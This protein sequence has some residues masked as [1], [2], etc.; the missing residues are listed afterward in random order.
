VVLPTPWTSCAVGTSQLVRR[1]WR[2][3]AQGVCGEVSGSDDRIPAVLPLCCYRRR[4]RQDC[5]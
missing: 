3:A 4:E 2:A 1:S 5:K